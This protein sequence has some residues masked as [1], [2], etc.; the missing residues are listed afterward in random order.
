[1]ADRFGDTAIKLPSQERKLDDRFG[2]AAR[3]KQKWLITRPMMETNK[4][5]KSS[6]TKDDN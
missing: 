4:N 1:L 2:N 6:N 3:Y 5:Y